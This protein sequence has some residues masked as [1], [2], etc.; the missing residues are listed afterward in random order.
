MKIASSGVLALALTR[1]SLVPLRTGLPHCMSQDSGIFRSFSQL[2]TQ[3]SNT[4]EF[5]RCMLSPASTISVGLQS[6]HQLKRHNAVHLV[7][8]RCRLQVN[9]R[10]DGEGASETR[11]VAHDQTLQQIRKWNK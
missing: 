8:G 9:G 2:Q 11:I 7:Q 10:G 6:G 1:S 5:G 4:Q 3:N